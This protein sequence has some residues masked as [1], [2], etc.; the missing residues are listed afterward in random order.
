MPNQ[1]WDFSV[2]TVYVFPEARNLGR[3]I[4]ISVDSDIINALKEHK[5]KC[6]PNAKDEIEA[7]GLKCSEV[8]SVFPNID[9]N[10]IL[11]V[12]NRKLYVPYLFLNHP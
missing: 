6:H 5:L 12:N 3:G 4:I 7:L 11:G 9:E 8:I 1:W 2:L 10:I